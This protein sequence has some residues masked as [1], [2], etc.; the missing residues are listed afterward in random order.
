VGEYFVGTASILFA[1]WDVPPFL[2][3]RTGDWYEIDV[4]RMSDFVQGFAS[5]KAPADAIGREL[6]GG[7]MNVCLVLL[8]RAG[9]SPYSVIGE[10]EYD[11][12]WMR[13]SRQMSY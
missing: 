4:D 8:D 11:F 10:R 13:L 3:D 2:T 6:A 12:N 9:R 5:A 1:A 7:L